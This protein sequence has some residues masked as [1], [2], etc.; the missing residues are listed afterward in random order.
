MDIFTQLC[1]SMDVTPR[2][3]VNYEEDECTLTCTWPKIE[4]KIDFNPLKTMSTQTDISTQTGNA[5]N[6]LPNSSSVTGSAFPSYDIRSDQQVRSAPVPMVPPQLR[7][8]QPA[9]PLISPLNNTFYYSTP[10]QRLIAMQH[11]LTRTR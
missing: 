9:P 5:P 6:T 10:F 8:G 1:A 3:R 11:L 4:N 2:F 7:T